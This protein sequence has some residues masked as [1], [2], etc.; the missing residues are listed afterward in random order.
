M[1]YDSL[2]MERGRLLRNEAMSRVSTFLCL[3]AS[4]AWSL[5]CEIFE[6]HREFGCFWVRIL[7]LIDLLSGYLAGIGSFLGRLRSQ[8]LLP[9]LQWEKTSCL[10][11]FDLS[12][13][14]RQHKLGSIGTFSVLVCLFV[15]YP[16]CT[17]NL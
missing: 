7:G 3:L 10:R 12:L 11:S 9:I 16:A 2:E 15:E 1:K 4:A 6:Q 5:F 17:R 13:F 14:E 8:S